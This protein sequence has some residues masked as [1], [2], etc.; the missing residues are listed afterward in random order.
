MLDFEP[1]LLTVVA[2]AT[3]GRLSSPGKPILSSFPLPGRKPGESCPISSVESLKKVLNTLDGI[4]TEPF[5]PGEGHCGVG[6]V[7]VGGFREI[8]G[9]LL[10]DVS[11]TA[12]S[13]R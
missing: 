1:E 5:T 9:I 4:V 12:R 13:F 3:D 2:L 8:E 11:S 6:D 10:P 7:A